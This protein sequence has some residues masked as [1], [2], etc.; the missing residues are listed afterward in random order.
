LRAYY[1]FFQTSIGSEENLDLF[2]DGKVD[3]AFSR[4]DVYA[5]RQLPIRLALDHH[6]QLLPRG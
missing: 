5:R 3:V 1:A 2:A 4:A 6:R